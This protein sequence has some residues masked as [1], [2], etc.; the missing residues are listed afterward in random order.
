MLT[1]ADI[2][3]F[4]MSIQESN[5][6]ELGKSK[7]VE[8]FLDYMDIK[9]NLDRKYFD[10]E[11][12]KRKEKYNNFEDFIYEFYLNLEKDLRKSYE[13]YLNEAKERVKYYKEKVKYFNKKVEESEDKYEKGKYKFFLQINCKYYEKANKEREKANI[14]HKAYRDS[15]TI[16]PFKSSFNYDSKL[17][18]D[19][20]YLDWEQFEHTNW[21]LM[22]NFSDS[23]VVFTEKMGMLRSVSID[24][25]LIEFKNYIHAEKIFE[26]IESIAE[27]NYYINKRLPIIKTA[28]NLFD[29]ENYTPLVYLLVTQ[30][31]GLFDDYRQILDIDIDERINGIGDKLEK[32]REK[33]KIVGYI[34]YAFDFPKIRN[35]I[36]HG[37]MIE[38]TKEMAF[39]IIMDIFY[40]VKLID[41]EENPYKIWVEF[42]KNLPE[43]NDQEGY[44]LDFFK[45]NS[46]FTEQKLEILENYFAGKYNEIIKWYELQDSEKEFI[47]IIKSEDFR[48]RIFNN[49]PIE[50]EKKELFNGEEFT[51]ISINDDVCQFQKLITLLQKKDFFPVDWISAV[52][53]RMK[54]IKEKEENLLKFVQSR[55]KRENS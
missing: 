18:L 25:Y 7:L 28:S 15:L 12:E 13:N 43:W 39:D 9:Y 26:N 53:N 51:I 30:V 35:D 14:F 1:L 4:I 5:P 47:E 8:R 45:S 22:I 17:K 29:V 32:L 48:K 41:A 38:V 23:P 2:H 11:F 6:R 27:K 21:K 49:E 50:R 40:I 55:R 24:N 19:I 46:L 54:E 31:E 20:P 33:K 34:Y 10:G 37:K 36:A 44:I 52:E 3:K 16:N 42:L